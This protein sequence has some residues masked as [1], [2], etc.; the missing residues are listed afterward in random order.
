MAFQTPIT[1]KEAIKNIHEKKYL[2]PAI[3][4]EVVW[5]TGQIERLF[6]SLM[7]DYPV[8][9]FLFWM[10]RKKQTG[11]YQFYEFVRDYH[12][13]DNP[14][15]AKAN[16][17]GQDDIIGILDGQQRLTSFYVGLRGS[18]AY[19]ERRKRWEN[20]QA[21][22]RRRLYL[23][24]LGASTDESRDLLYDFQ[25]LT[26]K[27]LSEAPADTYWFPVGKILDLPSQF[28]VN[29]F[30]IDAGLMKKDE[31]VARFANETLF[32]LW[33]VVHES[34]VINYFLEEDEELDKVL[35][36]FIRVNS[37]GT[38]LSYS[39]LLLSIAAAQWTTDAR[40]AVTALVD[41]IN[42]IGAGFD[43]DKDWVLKSC[44][45]LADIGDIAFKV[46]NFNKANMSKI[47]ESWEDISKALR[48]AV[49]LVSSFGYSRETLTSNNAVIPIAYYLLKR[50]LPS[51]FDQ[52]GKYA[53]DRESIQQ[54]LMMSLLKRAFGGQPDNVL[55]P[56]R[57]VLRVESDTFPADAIREKFKRTTK[58]LVFTKDD[59]DALLDSHYGQSYTFSV[60]ALLYPTLDFRN[61]FHIDHVH[62][63]SLFTRGILTKRAIASDDLSFYL[64]SFD[65]L[66]NLQLLEGIPNQEKNDAEFEDWMSEKYTSEKA[67]QGFREKNYIPDDIDLGLAN[68]REFFEKRR[69]LLAN[70]LTALLK[71]E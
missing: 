26:D 3:Q 41:E 48:N 69:A 35:N 8:G 53:P 31:K 49:I 4:R 50:G 68:F 62:P 19:K 32:K 39:D 67:A 18:F 16:V 51:N 17:S 13:R 9:S 43:V 27:E 52:A 56:I 60:L 55:R 42:R 36:I 38:I 25:F 33:S 47:E 64:D 59:I 37:G 70:R 71:S 20:P 1:I 11:N 24:L 7:R 30:L 44:L 22:P 10:V 66:P 65:L 61:T 54:W 45:V 28:Q 40:E 21:F 14:H 2:M 29:T 23:N 63:R 46:D 58:S 57:D 34:R 12:E 15:N 5:N 6:D